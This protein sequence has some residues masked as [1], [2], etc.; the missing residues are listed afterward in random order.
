MRG[1]VD[2]KGELFGYRV[3]MKL[4]TLDDQLTGYIQEELIVDLHGS[5]V[6]RV[7]GDAVY[8]LKE[9]IPVGYFGADRPNYY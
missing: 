1:L 5:P 2:T 7:V 8:T 6:W 4:Y 3:G 9:M